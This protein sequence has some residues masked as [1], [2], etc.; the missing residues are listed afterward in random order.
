[1]RQVWGRE[2]AIVQEAEMH[3][4]AN[5]SLLLASLGASRNEAQA[6]QARR[7][8]EVRRKL[9]TA[10]RV[11]EESDELS[12]PALRVERRS[13]EGEPWQGEEDSFGKVFSAKA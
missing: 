9:S 4:H 6:I 10:S 3:I 13:Y 8:A 7:A 12:S 2:V 11:L 5:N 1:L